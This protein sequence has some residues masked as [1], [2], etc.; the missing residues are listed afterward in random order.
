M[1]LR[2]ALGHPLETHTPLLPSHYLHHPLA[3]SY[4][5]LIRSIVP[6]R[7]LFVE[8]E[9]QGKCLLYLRPTLFDMIHR[10]CD[11]LVEVC[12]RREL[13]NYTSLHLHEVNPFYSTF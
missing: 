13:L 1:T 10:N 7:D 5:G 6:F 2:R 9:L 3:A 8:P 11:R 4:V 12:R